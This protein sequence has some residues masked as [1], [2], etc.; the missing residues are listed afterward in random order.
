[1]HYEDF[2]VFCKILQY[3]SKA[4]KQ[5][6]AKKIEGFFVMLIFTNLEVA[7]NQTEK[8]VMA[9]IFFTQKAKIY[10]RKNN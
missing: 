2:S 8:S 9:T 7:K 4:K 5:S 3:L 10:N 1:M 6:I